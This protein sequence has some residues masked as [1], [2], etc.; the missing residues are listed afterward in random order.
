[1]EFVWREFTI[2]QH[3]PMKI[4]RETGRSHWFCLKS[5]SKLKKK[6]LK[7]EAVMEDYPYTIERV[8]LH[9]QLNS[10]CKHGAEYI[11]MVAIRVVT[12]SL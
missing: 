8:H 12:L 7:V 5:T 1:M 2:S 10:L 11:A 9:M 4:S 3:G 6:A